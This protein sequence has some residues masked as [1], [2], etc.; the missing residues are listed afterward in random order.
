MKR[1]DP[2]KIFTEFRDNVSPVG[3]IRGRKY[4]VTHSDDTAE[5]FVTIGTQF[6]EDMIGALRDEVRLEYVWNNNNK[7]QLRGTAL[8]DG[9]NVSGNSKMRNE[10]FLREMPTALQAVR[11][12]DRKLFERFRELDNIP[13]Y[14][15]MQSENEE[16]N[17]LYDFGTMKDYI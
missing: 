12:G 9:E 11:Y 6:A 1:L 4:T 10:I 13:I 8:V 14:I 15:W 3:P 2:A 7:L 17:K 16:F 5:L